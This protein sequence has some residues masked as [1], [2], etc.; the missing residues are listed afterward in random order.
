MHILAQGSDPIVGA[1]MNGRRC[2][3]KRTGTNGRRGEDPAQ[4]QQ[5]MLR[6][7]RLVGARLHPSSVGDEPR[8]PS[9]YRVVQTGAALALCSPPA[10]PPRLLRRRRGC[11][12][13]QQGAITAPRGERGKGTAPVLWPAAERARGLCRQRA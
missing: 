11:S 13:R 7:G 9:A 8:L 3:G 12:L 6:R 4:P 1:I 2:E 5:G 10:A